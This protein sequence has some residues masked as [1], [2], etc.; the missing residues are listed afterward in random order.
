E[1]HELPGHGRTRHGE[2]FS[3]PI[4]RWEG[5]REK[6]PCDLDDDSL[7]RL[8]IREGKRAELRFVNGFVVKGLVGKVGRERG[9]L[10]YV[11]WRD[12]TVTRAGKVYF[13]PGWGEFDLAVGEKVPSVFGGPADRERYGALDI[14]QATTTPGRRT[15]Y[16]ATELDVFEAFRRV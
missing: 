13:E 5:A 15:P 9:K 1:G 7:A 14:G 4:G 12:C 3:S 10:V 11:T 16:S 2:G 8:G 6:S